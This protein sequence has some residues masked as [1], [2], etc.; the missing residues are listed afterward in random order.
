MRSEESVNHMLQYKHN[1]KYLQ[2]VEFN[3]DQITVTTDLNAAIR[4]AEIVIIAT[5]SAFLT[6]VFTGIG[7]RFDDR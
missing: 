5:P 1:P 7:R 3:L 2:S 6:S 4:P